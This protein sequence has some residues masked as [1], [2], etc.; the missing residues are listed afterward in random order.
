MA[1]CVYEG[2][3]RK[4]GKGVAIKFIPRS[5]SEVYLTEHGTVYKHSLE[6][7]LMHLVS[8]PPVCENVVELLDWYELPKWSSWS[9]VKLRFKFNQRNI[10]NLYSNQSS[11]NADR[12]SSVRQTRQQKRR[13]Y[14]LQLLQEMKCWNCKETP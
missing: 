5:E 12:A 6:V 8:Q 14:P 10:R 11:F 4:D 9:R 7:V 3:R 13:K 2:T 1:V